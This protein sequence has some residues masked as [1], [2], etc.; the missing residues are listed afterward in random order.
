MLW[1]QRLEAALTHISGSAPKG[2]KGLSVNTM[3]LWFT[4]AITVVRNRT[5]SSVAAGELGSLTDHLD[6]VMATIC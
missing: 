2:M 1:F 4:Q 5:M 3:L 6:A